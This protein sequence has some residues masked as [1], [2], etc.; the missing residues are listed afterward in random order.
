MKLMNDCSCNSAL[1]ARKGVSFLR[2]WRWGSEP[3]IYKAVSAV[4]SL[5]P[6]TMTV[7]AHGVPDG[8]SVALAEIGGLDS[9]N[10]KQWPPGESDYY[11]ATAV[12][13][14][15]LLLDTVDAARAGE[16]FTSGGKVAYA[17]PVDL[18]TQTGVAFHL[19]ALTDPNTIVLTKAC[20]L[21]N[22]AKTIALA[23]APADLAGLTDEQYTF[24]MLATGSD[25]VVTLID[26]GTL[27]L[28]AVGAV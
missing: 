10:A 20:T 9:V 16:S 1:R 4:T 28:D 23:I 26:D 11:G 14:N 24:N 13:A 2:T 18:S 15:T 25:G 12:D 19:Y 6:L 17:S 3:L 8:W 21:D 27:D 7:P 5:T 22:A